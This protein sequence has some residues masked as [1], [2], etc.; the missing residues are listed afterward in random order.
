VIISVPLRSLKSQIC[1]VAFPAYV[2]GL[3]PTK[4]IIGVSYGQDLA[5]KLNKDCREVMSSRWYQQVFPQTKLSRVKNT[6]AEFATTQMGYRLATSIDGTLTGR[7]GDIIIV[8]DPLKP[9]DALS[10]I[11]RE[12]VNNTFL[13][14]ILS[15]VKKPG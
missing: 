10:D 4:R 12:R 5:T 11:R 2:L 13:N 1:S 14:T 9:V 7:G 8:D 6:E 15:S 3:D